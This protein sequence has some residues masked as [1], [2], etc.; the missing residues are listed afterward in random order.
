MEFLLA[1][2]RDVMSVAAS[3]SASSPRTLSCLAT[4]AHP[5][6]QG[7]FLMEVAATFPF[8]GSTSSK[9]EQVSQCHKDRTM[10]WPSHRFPQTRCCLQQHTLQDPH[11]M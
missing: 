11:E 2:L 7:L 6:I 10:T 3:S 9:A 8:A 4:G 1:V 5:G